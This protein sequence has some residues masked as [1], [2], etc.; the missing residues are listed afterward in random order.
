MRIGVCRRFRSKETLFGVGSFFLESGN[1]YGHCRLGNTSGCFWRVFLATRGF[2]R[3]DYWDL[4][5]KSLLSQP[6]PSMVPCLPCLLLQ[7]MAAQRNT[8][9]S[10]NQR[11]QPAKRR[12]KKARIA[13]SSQGRSARRR[14]LF[15]VPTP[16]LLVLL[17]RSSSYWLIC[18]TPWRPGLQMTACEV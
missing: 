4:Q 6:C 8:T 5:E 17:R 18:L 10:T 7:Q 3:K 14:S 12:R 9:A 15:R 11:L 2:W 16:L 13:R 1:S